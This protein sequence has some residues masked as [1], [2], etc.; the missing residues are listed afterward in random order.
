MILTFFILFLELKI[1]VLGRVSRTSIKF[2][3]FSFELFSVFK[4]KCTVQSKKAFSAHNQIMT[5][6]LG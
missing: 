3:Y 2:L 1:L 5:V 4:D 6:R